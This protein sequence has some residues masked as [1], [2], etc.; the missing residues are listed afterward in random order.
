MPSRDNT[1]IVVAQ[2]HPTFPVV[3]RALEERLPSIKAFLGGNDAA[4]DRFRRVVLQSLVR[5][6]DLLNATP[7]SLASAAAEAAQLGL[8]PSGAVGGAHLV[9]F[10]RTATLMIDYRGLIELA[11]R[12]D[13]IED[14]FTGV[15]R[16]KDAFEVR[17]GLR[18][19]LVHEPDLQAAQGPSPDTEDNRVTHF[20]AVALF[21]SGHRRFEVMSRAEVDAIRA[22]SRAGNAGPWV[23]DYIAMGLKTVS[24]RLCKTLPLHAVAKEIIAADE[25]R[26]YG[27]PRVTVEE[28]AEPTGSLVER[29]RARRAPLGAD[30]ARRRRRWAGAG[31]A[32][33]ARGGSEAR[34]PAATQTP[35]SDSDPGSATPAAASSPP[36]G[37]P[38]AASDEP[39]FGDAPVD[40]R[41][42]DWLA[43]TLG[44]R[45]Q[46]GGG[47]TE[48]GTATA[49]QRAR[50]KTIFTPVKTD[51]TRRVLVAAFG[52]ADIKAISEAQATAIL[53]AAEV[54]GFAADLVALVEELQGGARVTSHLDLDTAIAK[55]QRLTDRRAPDECWPWKGYRQAN[56]YGWVNA[57]AIHIS[58]PRLALIADGRPPRAEEDACHHCDNRA[59]VNPS[60]LYAG[61]RAQNMADC[62]ARGRHNKPRGE[63]HWA[64]R[65]TAV[66]VRSIRRGRDAGLTTTT[67]AAMF[68]VHPSTISR[69]ARRVWRQEVAA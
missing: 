1:A 57:G 28:P 59:C 9:R 66:Q 53:D 46:M 54:K 41:P 15:V 55:L 33:A 19:D 35:T 45:A 20:Y 67:L 25:E 42:P 2:D 3:A 4:A 32:Q 36:G 16:E 27:G 50:L 24:R 63:E 10:G 30:E 13:Q 39:D 18:P 21:R 56:G 60:H 31:A 49:E 38:S 62:S 58:A 48:A 61:S 5:N 7:D 37:D 44:E 40:G 29:L 65:L 51:G 23:T 6:P 22:R 8:E 68:G 47:S 11:R 43:I 12:S 26:E 14:V 69:I 34:A 64:A 52:L 17:Q